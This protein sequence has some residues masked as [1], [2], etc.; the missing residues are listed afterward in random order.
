[1]GLVTYPVHKNLVDLLGNM[2]CGAYL[3]PEPKLFRLQSFLAEKWNM[4]INFF[5]KP[6]FCCSFP[7]ASTVVSF[8]AT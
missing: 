6:V 5:I 7:L 2:Y 3:M 1:M 8:K 4:Q